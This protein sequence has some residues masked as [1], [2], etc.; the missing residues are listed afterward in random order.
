M[1][2]FKKTSEEKK[3]ARLK[4]GPDGSR[5]YDKSTPHEP[6]KG[7]VPEKTRETEINADPTDMRGPNENPVQLEDRP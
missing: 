1:G 5:P 2:F 4:K 6:K 3:V 7:G